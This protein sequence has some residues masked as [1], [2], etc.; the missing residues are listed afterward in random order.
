MNIAD[1]YKSLFYVNEAIQKY[2]QIYSD[3]Y[4]EL[5]NDMFHSTIMRDE[6]VRKMIAFKEH[7]DNF[8]FV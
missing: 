2:Y 5:S 1:T 8:S 4:L 7:P 6:G 3:L